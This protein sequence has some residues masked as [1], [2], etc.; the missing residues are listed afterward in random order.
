[1]TGLPVV[2]AER[3]STTQVLRSARARLPQRA[4]AGH[5]HHLGDRRRSPPCSTAATRWSCRTSGRRR[6]RR[7]RSTA[8][9][10]NHQYSKSLD[11]EAGFRG[12]LADRRRT[13]RRLLL[14]AAAVHR[15]AG[16]PSGS[17]SSAEYHLDLPQLQPRLPHRPGHA[18]RP[19]VRPVRQVRVHRPDPGAVH[20]AAEPAP[21]CSAAPSRS[22]DPTLLP[23]FRG[24][25]VDTSG[26]EAVGVRRRRRRVPR[27]RRA[28]R[29]PAR[30]SRQPRCSR[31]RRRA[32]GDR[33]PAPDADRGCSA[34]VGRPL[35][36]GAVCHRRSP[37]LTCA[38]AGSAC[39][40]LGVEG[41][42]HVRKLARARRRA[43]AG[44]RPPARRRR[45][46]P[47]GAADRRAGST[48]S[49]RCDVVIKTPGISRYRAEV[50]HLEGGG[51]PV[52]GGLGLWLAE[53][54]RGAGRCASPGP[55]A[56]ARPPSIAGHLLRGPRP[57][58]AWSAATSASPPYDPEVAHDVDWWVVEVSSYQATDV[59]VAPPVVAVTSL[60][61]TTSTWHGGDV[62]TYYRDKLS[63]CTPARRRPHGR[64]TATARCCASAADLLGPRVEW[65]SVDGGAGRRL[66]R[67]PRPARRPQPR[68]TR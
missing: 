5:R 65:V 21:R 34:P 67:G 4:R 22:A 68:A 9:A 10:I 26:A 51:V 28:G 11:F 15:A 48:R 31:A 59:A 12:V 18:P 29:R 35:H 14:R 64:R 17:P 38:A 47:P 36:P 57:P 41:R 13:G 8:A 58:R 60:H 55:R 6:R 45:R 27:R 62:E 30:P 16:S 2:R 23:R 63:L 25:S 39:W 50:A 42:A 7:S 19:L 49:P 46:R 33:L 3:P 61:P 20:G 56:R 24:C 44:R 54:D 37:G 53:A 52:V 40:G 32:A 66:D 43:G 1:M